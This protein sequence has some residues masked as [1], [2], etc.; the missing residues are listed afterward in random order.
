MAEILLGNIKGE[1]GDAGSD[2]KVL[3]YYGTVEE[4]SAA[5]TNPSVGDV[6]GVGSE[7]PYDIYIYSASN[8]WVNNGQL[9]GAKGD[10]GERGQGIAEMYVSVD[11]TTGTP[12]VEVMRIPSFGDMTYQ[13]NF[14]GLKGE[15]GEKGDAGSGGGS[16]TVDINEQ[17]PTYEEAT[18][19]E[20][21]TSGEKLS[22][23][24]GKIKKAISAL[25][26][27]LT[28]PFK[29]NNSE[30]G[31]A[32]GD[33]AETNGGVSIGD[34]TLSEIGVAIGSGATAVYGVS[35]GADAHSQSDSIQLGHGTNQTELTLQVYDYPLMK[36]D[37][38]I[39]DE[40]IPHI[41]DTDVHITDTE[42][43][44]L[45]NATSH[46]ADTTKHIT[47]DERTEW[48]GKAPGGHGL[49]A[50]GFGSSSITFKE[51]LRKG[52]GFYQAGNEEDHPTGSGEWVG[53]I[54]LAR[55]I[56]EGSETGTQLAFYD[57]APNNPKM[58]MRTVLSGT[59][60]DWVEM[61]HSGNIANYITGGSG[62]TKIVSGSYTGTGTYISGQET[63][64]NIEA[65]Q[66]SI[67]FPSFPRLVMIKRR[68][69]KFWNIII[70]EYD[71]NAIEFYSYGGCDYKGGICYG[72]ITDD[73]KLTWYSSTQG[74]K[75]N[76]DLDSG[77][78]SIK[79][80]TIADDKYATFKPINQLN[81][82]DNDYDYIAVCE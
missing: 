41:S 31:V 48:N 45:N 66:N 33:S 40:R 54:Q 18:T 60:G 56:T 51:F 25:I 4:L 49:G 42:R 20:N 19:L 30:W 27:H 65:A 5:I 55:G 38:T 22:I 59:A 1:K 57:F 3:D 58:W 67:Q 53:L 26:L 10:K 37:G 74:W 14:S 77:L 7:H 46:I 32:F 8:G 68:V 29:H 69:E 70:P 2:F 13:I 72:E 79:L 75:Y 61:L 15:K 76:A 23:A 39:P 36:A 52:C 50:I 21:I 24:F 73:Y 81:W 35:I 34:D 63:Q 17:T 78:V 62:N 11:N 12:S 28:D 82:A 71:S 16:A 80:S 44:A 6:Y 9:Q 47:D 64:A 43:T